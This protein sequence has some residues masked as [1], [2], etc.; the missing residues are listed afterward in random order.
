MAP[1]VRKRCG[2]A[3]SECVTSPPPGPR[4]VP[5]RRKDV[6]NDEGP[7]SARPASEPPASPSNP[8]THPKLLAPPIAHH[9]NQPCPPCIVARARIT[10]I[11]RIVH[12][13]APDRIV[14][15]VLE[16]LQHH[17]F[18]DDLLGMMPILPE[19]IDLPALV[20]LLEVGQLPK[21]RFG[22]LL[23]EPVDDSARGERLEVPRIF[24]QIRGRRD[25]VKVIFH[26]DVAEELQ[27]AILL[28]ELPGAVDDLHD[29]RP[30]EQGE[31]TDEGR[32]HEVR[33]VGFVDLIAGM[34]YVGFSRW[35][36]AAAGR[37]PRRQYLLLL[38][39]RLCPHRYTQVGNPYG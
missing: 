12:I 38:V 7:A 28:E 15:H 18:A 26:D 10:P 9:L 17:L 1:L 23:L 39:P 34:R 14:V 11:R 19:L 20:R 13:P 2:S 22:S 35:G 32:G 4:S 29:V 30:R 5:R 21:D 6:C 33:L 24:A 37:R 27:P 8:G 3:C 25:P 36:K 16:L 31:P